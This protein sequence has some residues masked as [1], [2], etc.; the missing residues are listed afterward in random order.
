[1]SISSSHSARRRRL[2]DLVAAASSLR[3]DSRAAASLALCGRGDSVVLREL[4]A[5]GLPGRVIGRHPS[6]KG[7]SLSQRQRSIRGLKLG[8]RR[9][10]L[11]VYDTSRGLDL[12]NSP[13]QCLALWTEWAVPP[14]SLDPKHRTW[15]P[16]EVLVR[17]GAKPMLGHL[18][19]AA[20][21]A[22]GLRSEP[23]SMKIAAAKR[24]AAAAAW[25]PLAAAQARGRPAA[26]WQAPHALRDGDLVALQCDTGAPLSF[27]RAEDAALR[28]A[29]A[30]AAAGPRAA[31]PR[32]AKPSAR[33]PEVAL[34]IG[35]GGDSSDEDA[36]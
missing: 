26:L 28:A 34:Q 17:G 15:P 23:R 5:E 6:G 1:M 31:R 2:P 14:P 35:G 32:R 12:L 7:P 3:R 21:A 13:A 19:K 18:H 8:R 20:L 36:P 24:D 22:W 25:A 10:P 9:S 27:D 16:R 11:V 30:A 29:G 4:S 33:R